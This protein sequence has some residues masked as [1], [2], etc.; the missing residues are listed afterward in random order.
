MAQSVR[1]HTQLISFVIDELWLCIDCVFEVWLSIDCIVELWLP[2]ESVT[3]LW[4]PIELAAC[5]EYITSL[6]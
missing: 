1:T 3:E 6:K 5:W 4:L 2:S